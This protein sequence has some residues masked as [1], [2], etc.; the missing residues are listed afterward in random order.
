MVGLAFVPAMLE[1]TGADCLPICGGTAILITTAKNRHFPSRDKKHKL[2][3]HD[4]NTHLLP[5][6]YKSGIAN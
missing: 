1:Q 3:K 6:N 2:G 4:L 5:N